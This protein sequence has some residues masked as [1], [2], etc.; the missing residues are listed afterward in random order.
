MDY[1]LLSATDFFGRF[2]QGVT[3]VAKPGEFRST[4]D[5]LF[6]MKSVTNVT[7][8]GYGVSLLMQKPD[9]A[10]QSL[11]NHSEH[12]HGLAIYDSTF[13][14]V[15]N[16]VIAQTGGD[17]VYISGV[18]PPSYSSSH[19]YLSH[20]T[21]ADNYRQGMS[22]ISASDLLVDSCSF[23][24][25]NGTPPQAG[26]DL[27][28]NRPDQVLTQ[29]AFLNCQAKSNTGSGFQA[30]L[31]QLDQTTTPIDI[32]F[33]GCSVSGGQSSAFELGGL[34]SGLRG[35]IRIDNCT[36]M[37]TS[38]PGL[39]LV[40]KT[41]DSAGVLV[42]SG[43]F[44]YVAMLP[45]RSPVELDVRSAS[46]ITGNLT[47]QGMQIVDDQK[48]PY[49]VGGGAAGLAHVNFKDVKVINPFGCTTNLTK[50]QTDVELTVTCV[51]SQPEF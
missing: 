24:V 15:Y 14:S 32:S 46:T 20:V 25:T 44:Q 49:L 22:V 10:N 5:C 43:M 38:G 7:L 40:S 31:A 45:D 35:T 34:K 47:V 6:T 33:T 36:A 39:A 3:V 41:A 16:L 51:K 28:P 27:E 50:P 26:V 13:V 29:V 21:C 12:R 2:E 11:Y 8:Y 9:Y 42:N 23:R 19:I 18:E 30:W 4:N 17:G 48:R 1:S 37:N